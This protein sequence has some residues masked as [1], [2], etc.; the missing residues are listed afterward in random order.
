MLVF[1]ESPIENIKT[2]SLGSSY[3]GLLPNKS[4]AGFL[5][6]DTGQVF[7]NDW[8]VSSFQ[9]GLGYFVECIENVLNY[10]MGEDGPVAAFEFARWIVNSLNETLSEQSNVYVTD[11]SALPTLTNVYSRALVL[12]QTWNPGRSHRPVFVPYLSYTMYEDAIN[13]LVDAAEAYGNMADRVQQQIDQQRLKEEIAADQ[14][15]L[16]KNIHNIAKFLLSQNKAAQEQ[17]KSLSDYYNQIVE[18]KQNSL[19][20]ALT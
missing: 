15:A 20:Q 18:D 11:G 8:V 17:E 2:V 19:K 14:D 12:L 13:A 9:E 1:T 5:Y 6:E 3:S 7:K 4:T 16:N 10:N